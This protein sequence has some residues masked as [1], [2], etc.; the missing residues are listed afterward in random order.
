MGQAIDLP[1]PMQSPGP[2]KGPSADDLLAQ[3][4]GEEI[5]RLLAEADVERP[6][7]S[8]AQ[9]ATSSAIHIA[10]APAES[11]SNLNQMTAPPGAV[12]LAA[13]SAGD[14]HT[15]AEMVSE[16]RAQSEPELVS[17]PT[18]IAETD[19]E[20]L[21]ARIAQELDTLF[22]EL[23][24]DSP[25]P[26]PP[27]KPQA[28]APIVAKAAASAA[29]PA[30]AA[31]VAPAA[32]AAPLD[33]LEVTAELQRQ[34]LGQTLMAAL[35]GPLEGTSEPAEKVNRL[36]ILLRPLEWLNKPLSACSDAVREALGKVAIMTLI[37]ALAILVYVLFLRGH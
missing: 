10:T 8:P 28:Q 15:V 2:G 32:P 4:A 30:M 13:P 20:E 5:D 35:G 19:V 14:P 3:L 21:D 23:N 34:V 18:P 1:D 25:P 27:E 6:P 31:P 37:N 24:S 7:Y 36:E 12:V 22:T 26:P 16:P 33:P 17:K 9:A 11:H 29:A